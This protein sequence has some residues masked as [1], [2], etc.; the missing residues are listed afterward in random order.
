MFDKAISENIE[1]QRGSEA[2]PIKSIAKKQELGA[3]YTP[4][5]IA[6]I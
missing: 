6:K 5:H 4:L 1:D 2:I 3:Y